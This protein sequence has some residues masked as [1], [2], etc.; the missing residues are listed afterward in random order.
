MSAARRGVWT[1]LVAV[2]TALGL[3]AGAGSALAE[4]AKFSYTGNEQQFKVPAGVTSIE[5]TAIGASG[6]MG[7]NGSAGGRGAIVTGDLSVKKGETLYVLVGGVGPTGGFAPTGGGFNGGGGSEVAGGGGGGAS[8]VRTSSI[9]AEPSPGDKAS[10]ESRL[11]VAAGG[12]G[13]SSP[14]IAQTA[15]G[16]KQCN[17][18]R[19]GDA[20]EAGEAGQNCG[21][22]PGGGG[23]AGGASEGGAG[24]AGLEGSTS[25]E[26]WSGKPGSLGSGGL[27]WEQAGGGGGGKYGGGGGGAQALFNAGSGADGGSGGGG[28]GSNLVPGGGK[29]ELA[30]VGEA[31]SVTITYTV[32]LDPTATSVE[33]S[34][35]SLVAGGS[36][37]CTATVKDEAASGA[38]A[39][40]GN[41]AFKTSGSGSFRKASCTLTGSGVTASCEVTYKPTATTAKPERSDTI[42]AEYEGDEAH[43]GSEGTTTV[44]VISP[45]ALARGAFVI[46][47]NNATV[48]GSVTFYEAME[49]SRLN[50]LSGGS[51]PASFKGFAETSP[52]PPSCGE[53]WTSKPGTASAPPVTVPEYMEV[54]AA[55][56]ITQSGSTISGNATEVVVVKTSPGYSPAKK[57]TGNVVAVVCN[58]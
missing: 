19:A 32:T 16:A 17:G 3:L 28:G 50:S 57:G 51:G 10:L 56:K 47:N 55:S 13:G 52:T 26:F 5:V 1:A 30:K 34:P 24:G 38:S 6:G 54:V 7:D 53:K 31:A 41:V 25:S 15:P 43:K 29:E 12:G 21:F 27:G 2:V 37:K 18:G 36:T 23:G 4:E 22:P 58:T 48:G 8:D 44:T 42:T 20:G 45:T 14:E 11:I 39:P 46:G 49:W 33:C 9:G 35:A 40:M